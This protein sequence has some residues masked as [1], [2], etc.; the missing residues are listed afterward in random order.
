MLLDITAVVENRERLILNVFYNRLRPCW[1]YLS[2]FHRNLCYNKPE[3]VMLR[4]LE[5]ATDDLFVSPFR[6]NKVTYTSV[7]DSQRDRYT[8]CLW[9]LSIKCLYANWSS[10]ELTV[11]DVS[12]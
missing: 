6:Q 8:D 11:S 10:N 12:Q 2:A 4:D 3:I 7:T 9:T 1:M 5:N